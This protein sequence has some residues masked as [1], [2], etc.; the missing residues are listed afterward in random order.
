MSTPTPIAEIVSDLVT[1]TLKDGT[2]S[3]A[4]SVAL[5][6]ALRRIVHQLVITGLPVVEAEVKKS[7]F[8]GCCRARPPPPPVLVALP[9]ALTPEA[10]T[11]LSGAE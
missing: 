8:C 7:G 5:E 6:R 1:E 10:K 11:A 4:D 2:I 3:A 9:T